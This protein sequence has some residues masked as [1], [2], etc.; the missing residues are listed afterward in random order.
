MI[1]EVIGLEG[2]LETLFEG[3]MER[4]PRGGQVLPE[5]PPSLYLEDMSLDDLRMSVKVLADLMSL[6][7]FRQVLLPLKE[8]Y[9]SLSDLPEEE[10][11]RLVRTLTWK[12]GN[13]TVLDYT[14]RYRFGRLLT[15]RS[16][17][18]QVWAL[19]PEEEKLKLL[20]QDSD[21]MDIAQAARHIS[22]VFMCSR[23]DML[24]DIGAQLSLL[25]EPLYQALQNRLILEWSKPPHEAR[26]L[27]L[28]RTVTRMMWEVEKA[29]PSDREHLLLEARKVIGAALSL[30]DALLFPESSRTEGGQ[31]RAG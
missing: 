30:P 26:L 16:L 10:L 21:R 19:L 1:A 24:S 7:E 8:R 15:Q 22:R 11:K 13:R 31:G 29:D 2:S 9:P 5:E 14:G 4:L 18:P 17:S 6:E 20:L 23:Y 12:L 25:E 28:N 3:R 27:E